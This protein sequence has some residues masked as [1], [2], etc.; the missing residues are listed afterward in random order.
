MHQYLFGNAGK[1]FQT[2]FFTYYY[3]EM[4]F[5]AVD[6]ISKYILKTK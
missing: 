6:L 2:I 1:I 5:L 4:Q 3:L